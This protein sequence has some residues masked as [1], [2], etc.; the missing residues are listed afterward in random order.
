M[1]KVNRCG[2]NIYSVINESLSKIEYT[3]VNA[4][5]S[6]ILTVFNIHLLKNPN[7]AT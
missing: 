3:V 2:V 6:F 5:N 7:H 4:I 1:I